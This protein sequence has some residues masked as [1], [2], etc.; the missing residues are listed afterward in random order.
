M[1]KDKTKCK[2][3]NKSL[4]KNTTKSWIN[5]LERGYPLRVKYVDNINEFQYIIIKYLS[6][7]NYSITVY[8]GEYDYNTK[9]I[10]MKIFVDKRYIIKLLKEYIENINEFGYDD[11]CK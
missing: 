9:N 6:K 11:E 7:N 2:Y 10:Q 4:K 1:I 8:M 3:Y 5:F